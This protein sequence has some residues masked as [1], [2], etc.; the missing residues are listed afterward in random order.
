VRGAKGWER[1][2]RS[3]DQSITH[4]KRQH[5]KTHQTLK[6]WEGGE[7]GHNGGVS[8]F[9]VYC[10]HI[11]DYHNEALLKLMYANSKLK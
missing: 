11:W 8:L 3:E 5:N 4:P 6:R 2:L 1:K 9:E 10:T 7:H